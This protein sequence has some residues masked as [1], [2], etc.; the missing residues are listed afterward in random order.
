MDFFCIT[1]P[2]PFVVE[3]VAEF[4]LLIIAPHD[5]FIEDGA[6]TE[7]GL[8]YGEMLLD[9]VEIEE[10]INCLSS[11]G[12]STLP[13]SLN[14]KSLLKVMPCLLLHKFLLTFL[15]F[16]F[17]EISMQFFSSVLLK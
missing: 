3:E 6:A 14:K 17:F 8:E 15:L 13:F 16:K 5:E 11:N 4:P 12:F 10:R 1:N 9:E 2:D 7:S